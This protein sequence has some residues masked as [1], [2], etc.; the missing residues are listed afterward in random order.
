MRNK[1]LF[2]ILRHNMYLSFRVSQKNPYQSFRDSGLGGIELEQ[3]QLR[4]RGPAPQKGINRC[5]YLFT[6]QRRLVYRP[7]RQ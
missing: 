6:C 5:L 1:G 4:P 7:Q 2:F 3:K